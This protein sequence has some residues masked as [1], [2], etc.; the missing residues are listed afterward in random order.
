VIDATPVDAAVKAIGFQPASV[1]AASRTDGLQMQRLALARNVESEIASEWASA[2]FEGD[3]DGEKAARQKLAEWN[4]SNPDTPIGIT[5]G[6][7]QKRVRQMRMTRVQRLQKSAP[8]E[9]RAAD[10]R[11]A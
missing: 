7:I 6:Q 3:L 9:L 4:A 5:F 8:K 1:A 11:G 10:A 2:R